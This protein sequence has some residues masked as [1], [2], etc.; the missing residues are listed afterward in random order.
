MIR[1]PDVKSLLKIILKVLLIALYVIVI[2]YILLNIFFCIICLYLTNA[3]TYEDAD[4]FPIVGGLGLINA[5]FL[6][7]ITGVAVKR[8]TRIGFWI[9]MVLAVG[10][11]GV[12]VIFS[13]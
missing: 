2:C 7:V 5:V 6:N 13:I 1:K 12:L 4:G 9:H 10:C 11:L 3:W 8:F